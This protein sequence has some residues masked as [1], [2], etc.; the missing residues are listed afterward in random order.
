MVTKIYLLVI[1]VMVSACS[2]LPEPP[3]IT[4][5]AIFEEAGQLYAMPC[6]VTDKADFTFKCASTES[7]PVNRL[8]KG[9]FMVAPIEVAGWRR[10]GKDIYQNYDCKKK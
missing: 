5:Y 3:D 6:R 4:P 10:W 2:N 9:Y 8:F 7:V 1:L